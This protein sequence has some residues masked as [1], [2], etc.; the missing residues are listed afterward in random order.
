MAG[1]INVAKQLTQKW[2]MKGACVQIAECTYIYTGGREEGF[3]ARFINYPRF[4]KDN[5]E[6]V[7][8]ATELAKHLAT[9]LGQISFSIESPTLISTYSF[10]SEKFETDQS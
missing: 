9:E 5:S 8:D 2:A 7:S 6:I 10:R 1:D 3:T 4:P